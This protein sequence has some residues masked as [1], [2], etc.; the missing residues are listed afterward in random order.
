MSGRVADLMSDLLD[1]LPTPLDGGRSP[2]ANP[3]NPANRTRSWE[4]SADSS[5]C[6]PLRSAAN[7]APG[8]SF[9]Q[10]DSQNFAGLRTAPS[11]SAAKDFQAVSQDSQVS[12]SGSNG[13]SVRAKEGPLIQAARELSEDARRL[14]DCLL[15]LRPDAGA[16]TGSELAL[17]CRLPTGRVLIGMAQLMS[18]GLVTRCGRGIQPSAVLLR[19]IQRFDSAPL[20]R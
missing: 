7:G 4:E 18:A 17:A 20:S 15:W 6:E 19:E 2:A 8:M 1:S 3:A 9:E 13:R 11:S 5:F 16:L 10:P 14:L 12:Q